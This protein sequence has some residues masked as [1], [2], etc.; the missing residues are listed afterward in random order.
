M[1]NYRA[2]FIFFMNFLLDRA[3]LIKY[4]FNDTEKNVNFLFI[5]SK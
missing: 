1:L 3:I 2:L 5:V 4:E